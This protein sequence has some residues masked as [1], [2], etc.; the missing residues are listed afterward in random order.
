MLAL[1]QTLSTSI[2]ALKEEVDAA[3]KM[4][5]IYDST[6]VDPSDNEDDM[7]YLSESSGGEADGRF[8]GKASNIIK[9]SNVIK[10]SKPLSLLL[11]FLSRD[12]DPGYT[13]QHNGHMLN[14]PLIEKK[15][16]T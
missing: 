13:G 1:K 16:L 8:F 4:F 11:F 12:S 5:K 3:L 6:A 15:L 9:V 2:E 14:F 10:V 7:D